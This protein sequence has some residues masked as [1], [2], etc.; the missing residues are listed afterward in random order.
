MLFFF[1]L[2]KK[3]E[4]R[5]KKKKKENNKVLYLLEGCRLSTRDSAVSR[6]VTDNSGFVISPVV[7]L[8]RY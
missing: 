4:Q 1:F 5:K 7:Y 8:L 6:E 2:R 3:A